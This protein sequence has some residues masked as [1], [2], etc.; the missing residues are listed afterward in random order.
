MRNA[1]LEEAQAGIKIARRNI[2]NLRYA[3][4]TTLKAESEEELK[5]LLMKVKEENEKVGLKLNIQE[6]KTMASGPT[7]SWEI[8]GETGETVSDF[9][10]LGSKITADG[11]CSH[12]I[13]RCLLLGRK[14]MTNLDS[15]L[16]SRDIILSTKVHLV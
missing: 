9:I 5:S 14:V 12:K 15:I 8:D 7:T 4:D 1:G 10:F 13:K 2:N 16:K 6:T 11:N 3:D